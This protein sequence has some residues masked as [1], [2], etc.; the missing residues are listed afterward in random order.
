M[1]QEQHKIVEEIN[2]LAY[3]AKKESHFHRRIF[4]MVPSNSLS[5]SAKS[6]GVLFVSANAQIK[7]IKGKG[8]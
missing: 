3:S 7:N 8:W 6:N 5:H 1:P 4:R 2:I